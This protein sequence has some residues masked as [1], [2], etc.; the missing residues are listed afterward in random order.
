MIRS[1]IWIKHSGHNSSI[2]RVAARIPAL[3]HVK[4]DGEMNPCTP[5]STV[6]TSCWLMM[7]VPVLIPRT[8]WIVGILI[9]QE[10]AIQRL[11]QQDSW[12]DTWNCTRHSHEIF[13]KKT[14]KSKGLV[15]L[16]LVTLFSMI[17]PKR[18]GW[19]KG[20]SA[21]NHGLLHKKTRI[22]CENV[23]SNPERWHHPRM[24]WRCPFLAKWWMIR[25]ISFVNVLGA[26]R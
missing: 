21:E 25:D 1:N 14:A 5:M 13:A 4:V 23:P 16:L 17:Q 18:M 6:Q 26:S 9:I 8:W 11:F 12:N 20:H 7:L 10:L 2:L 3:T 24:L 22:S 19:L 15:T